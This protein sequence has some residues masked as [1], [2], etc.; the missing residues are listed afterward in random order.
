MASS[1]DRVG[2]GYTATRGPDPGIARHIVEALG[3]SESVVN[4]GAGTGS[5]EPADRMVIAVEPS[6]IMI[7]Q[8]PEGSAPVIQ[9]V[10]EH[11]PVLDG[12]V[13]CAL[14]ILTA[15]HWID[16]HR[17]FA[18]MRRV[19]RDRVVILCWDQRVWESFWLFCDYLPR[20]CEF[21][22][23]Q[24]LAISDIASAFPATRILPVP[25]PCDCVDGFHG[26]FWRRP[27]AYL[28]PDVR[29]GISTYAGLTAD[30]CSE[31]LRRLAED[32]DSG[33][34]QDRYSHLLELDELDLGYRLV[35][36]E[37]DRC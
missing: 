36:A 26:A 32:I 4:V 8:R 5:Y 17:G 22:R 25:I 2:V 24:A 12:A 23:Q 33:A 19:A 20:A 6:A 35:I 10:A 9:G 29:S 7:R 3:D 14:A 11:L 1:Y 21:D 37:W 18:E 15:H 34:W 16:P 30:D 13:D 31:G 27:Q 28:D